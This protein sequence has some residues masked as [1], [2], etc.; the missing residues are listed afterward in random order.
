MGCA[1]EAL[2]DI[3]SYIHREHMHPN[4]LQE[5]F[6]LQGTSDCPEEEANDENGEADALSKKAESDFKFQVNKELDEA[7]C[8]PK[9][10][11]H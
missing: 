1:E 8:T 2:A 9:C 6:L 5:L 4:Y 7:G 11:A 10:P 3:L